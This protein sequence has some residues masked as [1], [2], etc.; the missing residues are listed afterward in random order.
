MA[1]FVILQP[2]SNTNPTGK[3][4]VVEFDDWLESGN[5]FYGYTPHDSYEAAKQDADARNRAALMPSA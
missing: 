4:R 5:L 1:T 3:Y 2:N